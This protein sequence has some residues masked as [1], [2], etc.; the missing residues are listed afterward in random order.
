MQNKQVFWL[1]IGIGAA[2]VLA[3]VFFFLGPHSALAPSQTATSTGTQTASTTQVYLGNGVTATVPAGT[4]ITTVDTQTPPPSLTGSIS[5]SSTLPAD[6]QTAL[7]TQEQTLITELKAAPTR[8]DLWLELGVDRKIGG[9]YAG[10]I[11]AWN[12]VAAAGSNTVNYVA[13]GNLGDLYM[14][15]DVNYPK[16]EANYKAAIAIKPTV[17]DYYRDLYTLYTSFYKTGTSAA[18]SI[19]AQGLKANPNNPDLLQL[20]AQL[21]TH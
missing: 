3:A 6:V 13:D 12:Y 1:I 17:I 11:A 15:F 8:T 10:A 4:T 7:R 14:N 20:Q 21:G 19:V 5:I 2:I 9:D 18:A 16:A